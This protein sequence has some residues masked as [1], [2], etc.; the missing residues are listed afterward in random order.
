MSGE[1]AQECGRAEA[2]MLR[3]PQG[4]G[5][6]QA[7]LEVPEAFS[8]LIARGRWPRHEKLGGLT[9]ALFLPLALGFAGGCSVK[10]G[11]EPHVS[12]GSASS[13]VATGDL[14]SAKDRARLDAITQA[15]ARTPS[16]MAIALGP[17]DLLDI[18][19]P[20]LFEASSGAAA[21]RSA[22][23][24]ADIPAVSGARHSSKAF[25]SARA[26]T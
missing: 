6:V 23:G 16:A 2:G 26:V 10:H 15:R 1:S 20:D 12:R 3:E 17:D 7:F 5:S 8:F 21:P 19:I 4:P 18:R 9:A 14:T 11:A 25:A 24:S 22:P 13:E